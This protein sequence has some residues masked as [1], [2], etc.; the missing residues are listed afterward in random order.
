MNTVKENCTRE[1][2]DLIKSEWDSIGEENRGN[3]LSR[4]K[5]IV[6]WA[7]ECWFTY[8]QPGALMIVRDLIRKTYA[9]VETEGELIETENSIH[10]ADWTGR[11]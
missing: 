8:D 7:M 11:V 1:T 2:L 6:E 3:E 10:F 5:A 4:R 9:I